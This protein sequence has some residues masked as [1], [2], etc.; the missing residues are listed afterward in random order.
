L[1]NNFEYFYNTIIDWNRMSISEDD[2]KKPEL[3]DLYFSLLKEEFGETKTAFKQNDMVELC[4]GLGDMYFVLV[5]LLELTKDQTDFTKLSEGLVPINKLLAL[6][7]PILEN[8]SVES[9]AYLMSA[10]CRAM[11]Y[12]HLP[13]YDV[14]GEICKS[15]Y[16]KYP[17][18]EQ[19][20]E[21]YGEDIDTT[22]SS[23]I[24]WINTKYPQ[25]ENVVGTVRNG[26]V[27]FRA[28]GGEGKILK[29][30]FF[31]EPDLKQYLVDHLRED[32]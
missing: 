22:I 25:Y 18:I 30:V 3:I 1:Q 15:N 20:K 10:L 21:M 31:K 2:M 29:S 26:R 27:V 13:M 23:A 11:D 16:T 12:S 6:A 8:K 9:V 7:E 5:M 28:D 14:I 4:D 24:D 17:T 32:I 19:V